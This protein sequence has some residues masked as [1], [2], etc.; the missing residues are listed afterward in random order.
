MTR[1]LRYLQLE[2]ALEAIKKP[3][4]W[5]WRPEMYWIG[6][7]YGLSPIL[8]GHDEYSR[9][10]IVLGWTITGRICIATRYCGDLECYE[11]SLR[12]ENEKD[13]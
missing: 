12:W 6:F 2:V 1:L 13:E 3:R 8:R 5:Y 7:P 10:T 11:Q 4:I 9:K